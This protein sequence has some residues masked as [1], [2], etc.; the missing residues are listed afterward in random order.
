MALAVTHRAVV[1]LAV[2]VALLALLWPSGTTYA[3]ANLDRANPSPNSVLDEAPDRVVIWFT[4][5]LEPMLSEI[6]V[7]DSLGNRVDDGA[8]SVD[9]NDPT[10]MSVGLGPVPDG[11]YTVAWKT[12]PP[13]MDTASGGRSSS[14]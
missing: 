8:S 6:R 5:P 2:A 12:C 10:V 7:L 1:I 14:P 4:E 9:P 13:W 3:H 11:T